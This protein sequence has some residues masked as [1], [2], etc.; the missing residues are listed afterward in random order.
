MCG[1]LGVEFICV[2]GLRCR[3]YVAAETKTPAPAGTPT[4][5]NAK[6]LFIITPPFIQ[7][8]RPWYC[9]V[10]SDTWLSV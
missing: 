2:V 8:M 5:S 3:V 10:P 1:V 9:T 7:L 4:G 6:S